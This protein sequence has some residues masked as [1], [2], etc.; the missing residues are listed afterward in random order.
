MLRF[1]YIEFLWALAGVPLFVF[2]F[3]IV[4]SW[5]RKALAKLGS[6][7]TV[8]KMIPDVSFSRPGIKF[9]LFLFA[10]IALVIGLA[11]PQIGT[12]I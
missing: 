6:N 12:K 3:F 7:D 1:A 9:I 4:R 8:R 2:V 11:N 10:Y 5:K